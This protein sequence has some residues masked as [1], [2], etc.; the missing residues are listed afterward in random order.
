MMSRSVSGMQGPALI[1]LGALCFCTT[2]YMQA[3][4]PH[5]AT[6]YVIGCVRMLIG[7]AALLAWCAVRGRLPGRRGWPLGS[8]A[9]CI[10]AVLGF[11]LMFFNGVLLAGVAVGTVVSIGVTPLSAALLGWIF[12]RER[13]C[14]A[15]YP[16]TAM[17]VAGL[18]LINRAGLGPVDPATVL[19][20]VGAGVSFSLFIVF[21][22]E[23]AHRHAPDTIMAVVS[24]SVG[25][26]MIPSLFLY[27][28]QWLFTPRGIFVALQLG[29]VT[30]AMAFS[31]SLAGYKTTSASTASTVALAEPLGAACLGIFALHEPLTMATLLGM[32]LMFAGVLLLIVFPG[33]HHERDAGAR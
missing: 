7:G 18:I 32:A 26:L 12:L 17:A 28:T 25:V 19:L 2:G 30:S 24:L 33:Q 20:P 14:R 5:G 3:V 27:P 10:L 21:S 16:A 13:P 8:L 22:R 15:W 9:L 6:P 31:L 23:I 29:V 11:Q 4:A 1:L